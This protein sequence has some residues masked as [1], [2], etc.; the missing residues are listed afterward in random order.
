MIGQ[1]CQAKQNMDYSP[2]KSNGI[3]QYD[4]LVVKI[5]LGTLL[6]CVLVNETALTSNI[7]AQ[8][9]AGFDIEYGNSSQPRYIQYHAVIVHSNNSNNDAKIDIG[10]EEGKFVMN[11]KKIKK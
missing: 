3:T 7:I 5:T 4:T 9:A 2:Y 6:K 10:L 8:D 11:E 1:C